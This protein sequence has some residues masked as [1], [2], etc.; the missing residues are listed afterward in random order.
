MQL[1]EHQHAI[2]GW[3]RRCELLIVEGVGGILCPITDQETVADL[4]AWWGRPIII[5][6]RLGLGT[7]NHTLMTVEIAR[8]RGL[9][10]SGVLLN[11]SEKGAEVFPRRQTQPSFVV[12]SMFQCGDRFCLSPISRRFPQPFVTWQ[13][14]F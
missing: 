2:D 9:N 7:L 14:L 5:V 4:A 11:Q 10:L 13:T 6:A 8:A 12:F 1:S 3:T